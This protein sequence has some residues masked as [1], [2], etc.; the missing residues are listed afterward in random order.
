MRLDTLDPSAPLDD[1]EPLRA[2]IGGARVVGIG[3]A[4]HFVREFQLLREILTPLVVA[5]AE[6]SAR[7]DVHDALGVLDRLLQQAELISIRGLRNARHRDA[8]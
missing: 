2:L 5:E 1:L 3:E 4:N 8:V 7:A 6:R